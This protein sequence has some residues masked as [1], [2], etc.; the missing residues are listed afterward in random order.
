MIMYSISL[1]IIY[2]AIKELENT[3]SLKN[4]EVFLKKYKII[5][6]K[7]NNTIKVYRFKIDMSHL[8][9]K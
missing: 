3:I 8:G 4:K 1:N 5:L 9:E 2:I 7:M 6:Q